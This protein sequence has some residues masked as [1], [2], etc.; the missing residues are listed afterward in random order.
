MLSRGEVSGVVRRLVV[1]SMYRPFDP[2]FALG[3]STLRTELLNTLFV[4]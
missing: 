3:V 1:A 4:W 2:A